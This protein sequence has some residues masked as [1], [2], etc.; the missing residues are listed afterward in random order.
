LFIRSLPFCDSPLST[1]TKSRL[2]KET[3]TPTVQLALLGVILLLSGWM[4]LAQYQGFRKYQTQY[5]RLRPSFD[6]LQQHTDL[7]LAMTREK[8]GLQAQLGSQGNSK[9]KLET[10]RDV[11]ALVEAEARQAQ[12]KILSFPGEASL[13]ENGVQLVEERVE[14][15]G[16]YPAIVKFLYE[17]EQT[18]RIGQLQSLDMRLEKIPGTRRKRS[19]LV[20]SLVFHRPIGPLP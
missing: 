5:Q 17:L 16:K 11:V 12:V 2:V 20:A 13:S 19:H 15:S 10:H 9:T 1:R 4:A 18:H 14:I 8:K 7:R 6:S 3:L